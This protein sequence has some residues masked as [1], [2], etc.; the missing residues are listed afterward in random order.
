MVL[1]YLLMVIGSNLHGDGDCGASPHW[2]DLGAQ[3]P[4][5]VD[6]DLS[7]SLKRAADDQ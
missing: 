7:E 5:V 6:P 2:L 3:V 1:K 4:G